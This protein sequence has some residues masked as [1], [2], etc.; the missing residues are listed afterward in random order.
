MKAA[1]ISLLV[2]KLLF[3]FPVLFMFPAFD[4]LT[5]FSPFFPFMYKYELRVFF[6]FSYESFI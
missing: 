3:K 2:A 6:Y 4:L 1:K 5:P